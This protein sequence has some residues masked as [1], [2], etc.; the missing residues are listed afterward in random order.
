[1]FPGVAFA[2]GKILCRLE[3]VQRDFVSNVFVFPLLLF[4]PGVSLFWLSM[5]SLFFYFA[6]ALEN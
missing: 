2:K 4:D 5:L 1:M 6:Q 3:I